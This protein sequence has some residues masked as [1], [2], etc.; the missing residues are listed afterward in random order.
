M[1]LDTELRIQR[2]KDELSELNPD[3]ILFDNLDGALV[4][5]GS[6]Y[7]N[8]A[9]A[10]YS[11]ERILRLLRADMAGDEDEVWTS[12]QEYYEHNIAGLFAGPF[13]PIIVHLTL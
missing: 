13:T 1:G 12:A 9:C 2:L 8:D 5:I 6:S 3:A 10:V 7:P 11:E 4:G